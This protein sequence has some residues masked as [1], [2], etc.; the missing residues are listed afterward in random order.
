MLVIE[1]KVAGPS[2][3]A[4]MRLRLLLKALLIGCL[5]GCATA[6]K[7]PPPQLAG[8]AFSLPAVGTT[9][10]VSVFVTAS[11]D[12]P[13]K[14]KREAVWGISSNGEAPALSVEDA[15]ERAG[16]SDKLLAALSDESEIAHV[17][18]MAAIALG[19]STAVGGYIGCSAGMGVG[20]GSG[21]IGA[22][23]GLALCAGGVATG[24]AVGLVAA[25]GTAT[26]YGIA[27]EARRVNMI[28]EVSL[29]DDV[30]ANPL[31]G[32]VFLPP[33][34]YSKLRLQVEDPRSGPLQTLAIPVMVG[35]LSEPGQAIQ[36]A[37][38]TTQP[39]ILPP[40]SGTASFDES[41]PKLPPVVLAPQIKSGPLV[42]LGNAQPMGATL[43]QHANALLQ[44]QLV[45]HGFRVER[46]SESQA[47]ISR[48][49]PELSNLGPQ[50]VVT[51]TAARAGSS[52]H[53]VKD[54]TANLLLSVQDRTGKQVF[55][56]I[57]TGIAQ[58]SFPHPYTEGLSAALDDAAAKACG[59][60]AFI[61]AITPVQTT[62]EAAQ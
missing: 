49:L 42:G 33:D 41:S 50:R 38:P 46:S 31:K 62:P 28:R 23:L 47:I 58:T 26:Y 8:A 44:N 29:P 54:I 40:A 21:G 27:G 52:G 48:S 9:I 59:D 56:Q 3:I 18:K 22:A 13:I 1:R 5:A 16:G 43:A 61:A 34:T 55:G 2:G 39:L 35:K 37:A 4:R 24:A 19:G 53:F 11:P 15:A 7:P 17:A 12:T 30:A 6:R 57:Y 32:Y 60:P 20:A 25:A 10:P 51:V 14:V 45:K 36:G